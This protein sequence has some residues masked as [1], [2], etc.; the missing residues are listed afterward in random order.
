MYSSFASIIFQIS[1]AAT[2]TVA[3]YG[4]RRCHPQDM[5]LTQLPIAI[6]LVITIIS[7]RL[8]WRG[9]HSAT[10]FGRRALLPYTLLMLLLGTAAF[11]FQMY[12]YCTNL[13]LKF[14]Q[15]GP[16]TKLVVLASGFCTPSALA[17]D[18]V[19]FVIMLTSDVFLVRPCAQ[20]MDGVL[21]HVLTSR[22]DLPRICHCAEEATV[23]CPA[24]SSLRRVF[25]CVFCLPSR[26]MR[27]V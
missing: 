17:V 10:S 4:T 7:V 22:L 20:W 24:G 2:V 3:G 13:G 8:L 16:D 15:S 12:L 19:S 23:H 18:L 21:Y 11:S 6:F 14:V 1:A 9:R 27:Q 5:Q 25:Q 26:E